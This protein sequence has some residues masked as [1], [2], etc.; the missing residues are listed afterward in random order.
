MHKSNLLLLCGLFLLGNTHAQQKAVTDKGI[1][2]VLYDD[3]T[4]KYVYES[5][6]VKQE[7]QTNPIKF[8]KDVSSTFLLKS[9]K[10]NLGFY[11]NPKNWSFEKAS[12]ESIFEYDLTFK[13]G[14]LYGRIITEKLEVPI[15]SLKEIAIMN[16]KKASP[17]I[18][19]MK[20]EFRIVNGIKLLFLQLNGTIKGIKF[21]FFGY[22]YSDSNGA[23]QFLTYSTESVAKENFNEMEKLLNGITKLN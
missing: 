21:T 11:I 23:L 9:T 5:E 6:N 22:Y 13:K 2:V 17:D 10:I 16:A 3:G 8:N 20:E 1:E 19:V 12:S 15:E 7:I 14:E 4:W 18:Q